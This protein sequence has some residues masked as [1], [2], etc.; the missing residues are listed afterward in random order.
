MT[1]FEHARDYQNDLFRNIRGIQKSQHLFDDLSDDPMD[2]EAANYLDI[3]TH[4]TLIDASVIQ[5]AFDYSKNE[6][7]DYP[8]EHITASRYND[9]SIP[10]WY[11]SETL[12]TTVFETCYHF[13]QEIHDAYDY[14]CGQSVITIDRRVAL[15]HCAS[16]AF[17]LSS[18]ALDYPWLIDSKNYDP[19][20]H[21]GRRV[22]LEGHPLLLVP[23]ARHLG[24][25]NLVV[26]NQSI[27]SNCRDYCYL[28]YEYDIPH[29]VINAYRGE[30]EWLFS[31]PSLPPSYQDQPASV[32]L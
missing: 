22:A 19:C 12:E 21:L 13:S 7:I 32:L 4:P 1:L 11:G 6:F 14:F 30:N 31:M 28:K 25:V 27:L 10:C 5:R 26:F 2:W 23:S 9:G 24:G 3:D 15:V 20:Q 8:F 18:K 16:L 17:D 29:G